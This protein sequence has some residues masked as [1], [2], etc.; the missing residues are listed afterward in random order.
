VTQ[1]SEL[2]HP[3]ASLSIWFFV[4]VL[5]LAYGVVLTGTGLY[6]FWHPLGAA[7]VLS[8][9]HATLWW[10]ILMT[11]FGSFYAIRFRPDSGL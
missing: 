11:L 10:G 9:L 7:V 2:R 3:S 5:T 6:E 4:G 8:N 1:N